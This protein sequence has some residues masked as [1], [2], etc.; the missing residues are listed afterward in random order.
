M[1]IV[2]LM[3]QEIKSKVDGIYIYKDILDILIYKIYIKYLYILIILFL[4]QNIH[5]QNMC[6]GYILLQ[7]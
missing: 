2:C 5:T 4:E 3:I 1:I 7:K 6:F